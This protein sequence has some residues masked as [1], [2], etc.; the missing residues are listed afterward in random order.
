MEI[1]QEERAK[2][3][4]GVRVRVQGEKRGMIHEKIRMSAIFSR[5]Y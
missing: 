3:G 2:G 5:L 1:V 4:F